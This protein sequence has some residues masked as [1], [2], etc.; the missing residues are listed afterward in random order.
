MARHEEDRSL[1]SM[2]NEWLRSRSEA[3]RALKGSSS[4][5]LS[6]I[7][8]K[9]LHWGKLIQFLSWPIFKS[10]R[11]RRTTTYVLLVRAQVVA[12][13]HICWHK[14]VSR[15]CCLKPD[16]CRSEERRVG[17]EWRSRWAPY[18]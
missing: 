4:T 8:Q 16:R 14:Q 10:R 17:K 7:L 6:K 9:N 12:W 3:P 5:F 11:T 1:S 15:L 2:G 13:L 18:H